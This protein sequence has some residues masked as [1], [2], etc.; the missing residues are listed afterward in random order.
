M[1]LYGAPYSAFCA[2]VRV[3][4]RL[5]GIAFEEV[6]PPGGYRSADFRAVAPAGTIPALD[7]G[8]RVLFES[9]AIAEFVDETVGTPLHPA[10]P[11]KRAQNRAW[12]DFVPTF[13]SGLSTPYYAK[14]AEEQACS[15]AVFA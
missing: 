5:K 10:D 9:N 1:L 3:A 6:P 11:I 4:L 13:S 2:K 7:I 15:S 8:G 14:T 12:T